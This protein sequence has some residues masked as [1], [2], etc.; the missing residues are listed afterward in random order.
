MKRLMI[1]TLFIGLTTILFAENFRMGFTGAVELLNKPSYQEIL[2]EFDS[3]A[4]IIPGWYWE[5]IPRNLGFG[6][7]YLTRFNRTSSSLANLENSWYFDWIGTW[8]FRYHFFRRFF[9]D[10][11]LEAGIGNAGRVDITAYEEYGYA[12]NR[13]PLMLSIFGQIGGGLTVRLSGL[14]IGGKLL[15]RFINEIPP[16]TQFEPYPLKNFQFALFGGLSF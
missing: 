15:Y 1:V 9:L 2:Q 6:M 4:N 3:Q 13:E 12:E 8:D 5:V 11:F 7:S 16:A 10:P 14:H